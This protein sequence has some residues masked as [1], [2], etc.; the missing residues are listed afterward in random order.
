MQGYSFRHLMQVHRF[1]H[2][3]FSDGRDDPHVPTYLCLSGM[4]NTEKMNSL[5]SL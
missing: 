2:L 3:S 1:G 5:F 4:I